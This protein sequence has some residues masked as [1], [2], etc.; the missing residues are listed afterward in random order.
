[1]KRITK[2]TREAAPLVRRTLP[3]RDT[4][5]T[6]ERVKGIEPSS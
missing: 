4:K 1:M 2:K 3:R 6:L 5:L